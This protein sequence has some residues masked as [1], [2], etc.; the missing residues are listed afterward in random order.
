MNQEPIEFPVEA[1]QKAVAASYGEWVRIEKDRK[2]AEE[3]L[4]YPS[5]SVTVTVRESVRIQKT[6]GIRAADP[7]QAFMEALAKFQDNLSATEKEH[8]SEVIDYTEDYTVKTGE[9]GE[10]NFT[11]DDDDGEPFDPTAYEDLS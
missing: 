11:Q 3:S 2:H 8:I 5:F 1:W 9:G 10:F 6:Y 7:K 4:D